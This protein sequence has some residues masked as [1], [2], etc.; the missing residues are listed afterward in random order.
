MFL[1]IYLFIIHYWLIVSLSHFLTV[2][3]PHC[4]I[5]LL[6]HKCHHDVAEKNITTNKTA[7][8]PRIET[9]SSTSLDTQTHQQSQQ[10]IGNNNQLIL[11]RQ[12]S[13]KK[14]RLQCKIFGHPKPWVL[15]FRNGKPIKNRPNRFKMT[16][17]KWVAC[18]NENLTFDNFII[19][20]HLI[21]K[22]YKDWFDCNFALAFRPLNHHRITLIVIT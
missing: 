10:T 22:Y 13:N 6:H 14:L 1:F 18:N 16:T 7:K 5:V 21:I 9:V 11:V 17:T 20:L 3:L 19:K 12:Q 2:S 4:I 15:W 8:E